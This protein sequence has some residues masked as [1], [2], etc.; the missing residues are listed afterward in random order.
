MGQL[1]IS[2]NKIPLDKDV[3]FSF[4]F[5]LNLLQLFF[6]IDFIIMK[7]LIFMKRCHKKWQMYDRRADWKI[8][9]LPSS[10]R[11]LITINY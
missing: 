4:S 11:L 8:S 7:S 2:V 6:M 5:E 10:H 1:M 3:F 9:H